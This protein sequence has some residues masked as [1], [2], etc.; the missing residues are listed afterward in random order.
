MVE[1]VSWDY[2]AWMK[3]VTRAYLGKTGIYCNVFVA[4]AL[5]YAGG[6]DP[7]VDMT[8]KYTSYSKGGFVINSSNMCSDWAIRKVTANAILSQNGSWLTSNEYDLTADREAF[9][10]D[11]LIPGDVIVYY[12]NGEPTHVGIY[13]GKFA[14]AKALKQYLR[15]FGISAAACGEQTVETSLST[16]YSRAVWV[17]VIRCT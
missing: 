16:G 3:K 14:T 6:S 11:A 1:N 13:F 10:Y 5:R 15:G 4:N 12:T 8:V 9:S 2:D 17:A 7:S